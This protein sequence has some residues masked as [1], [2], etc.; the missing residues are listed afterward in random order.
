MTAVDSTSSL[1]KGLVPCQ[2]CKPL[3]YYCKVS[4]SFWEVDDLLANGHHLLSNPVD[5]PVDSGTRHPKNP[6]NHSV[7]CPS[8]QPEEEHQ[9]L[10]CGTPS[11]PSVL[12]KQFQQHCQVVSVQPKVQPGVLTIKKVFLEGNYQVHPAVYSAGLK[13]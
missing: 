7:Q 8:S 6:C 11:V 9:G 5:D 13:E 10:K 4:S 12:V 2:S 3:S 1:R